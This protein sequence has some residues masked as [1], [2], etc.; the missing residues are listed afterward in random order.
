M[1]DS[2]KVD[3]LAIINIDAVA[4]GLGAEALEGDDDGL[5][6]LR[7][8]HPPRA[9]PVVGVVAGIAGVGEL[10]VHRARRQVASTCRVDCEDGK[11]VRVLLRDTNLQ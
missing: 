1:H 5:A 9:A 6:L 8:A 10:L 11:G 4:A 3:Q 7:S 2:C